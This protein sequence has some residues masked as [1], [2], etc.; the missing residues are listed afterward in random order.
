MPTLVSVTVAQSIIGGFHVFTAPAFFQSH[1]FRPFP[2][3]LVPPTGISLRAALAFGGTLPVKINDGFTT[4]EV[5][6]RW[7]NYVRSDQILRALECRAQSLGVCGDEIPLAAAVFC[8]EI[9]ANP[10][11]VVLLDCLPK[12]QCVGTL[13]KQAEAEASPNP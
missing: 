5:R 4:L 11:R 2:V 10:F 8:N 13:G 7:G 3:Q 6:D 1:G 9:D 12:P